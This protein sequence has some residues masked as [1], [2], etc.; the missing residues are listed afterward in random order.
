MPADASSAEPATAVPAAK[1]KPLL[2]VVVAI[3]V[4]AL[5]GAGGFMFMHH[6]G[7]GA[8]DAASEQPKEAHYYALDPSIVVNFEDDRAIRF[9][10]VGISLMAYDPKSI[11]AAKAAEPR[12]RNVLLLLFSGQK[13]ATLVSDKG[14][15]ELQK[16]ALQQ[17]QDV[18][19]QSP[20]KPRID[21]L[22][23]TSFVIQ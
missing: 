22:Y 17:V 1:K 23:F 12:I 8:K 15:L 18:L 11:D 2:L 20:G 3:V 19:Q 4:V 21:A 10:Q 6:G 13:Y 16:Q 14:K 5:L 7:K 9:L